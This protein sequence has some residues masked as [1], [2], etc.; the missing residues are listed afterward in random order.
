MKK[1]HKTINIALIFTLIGVFLGQEFAYSQPN[2]A[3]RVPSIFNFSN[4]NSADKQV[5]LGS[6]TV[7][8][9]IM[10]ALLS[11]DQQVKEDFNIMMT[12]KC[13]FACGICSARDAKNA[14]KNRDA[15]KESLFSIFE[16]YH[17][18]YAS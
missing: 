2:S 10:N 18:G 17:S 14:G 3:L 5:K 15:D 4:L 11:E 7:A 13:P 6:A 8:F 9:R 1:I 16:D 12:Y